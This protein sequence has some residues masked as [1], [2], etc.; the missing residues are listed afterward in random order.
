MHIFFTSKVNLNDKKEYKRVSHLFNTCDFIMCYCNG[1]AQNYLMH[2]KYEMFNNLK[3]RTLR[4]S[5]FAI[6]DSNR[7]QQMF[8]DNA[9]E[10]SKD[11]FI[12]HI[13]DN[14]GRMI[15]KCPYCVIKDYEDILKTMAETKKDVLELDELHVF[16]KDSCQQI[17]YLVESI[18]LRELFAGYANVKDVR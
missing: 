8:M 3:R 14:D 10:S 12:R 7:R 15:T 5:K 6:H 17:L 13:N 11:G 2:N 16:E 1:C 4:L 18:F 9:I